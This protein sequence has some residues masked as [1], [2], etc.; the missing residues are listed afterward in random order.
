MK[1]EIELSD[2][3][4][5]IFRSMASLGR[6][7]DAVLRVCDS[8]TDDKATDDALLVESTTKDLKP[9]LTNLHLQLRDKLITA[10][11]TPLWKQ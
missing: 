6:Y 7:C 5:R 1:I 9:A 11:I 4:A 8:V 10:G 3:D 2:A